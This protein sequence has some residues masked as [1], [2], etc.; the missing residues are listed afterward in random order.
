MDQKNWT[1]LLLVLCKAVCNIKLAPC[2]HSIEIPHAADG[3]RSCRQP[4]KGGPPA[5]GLSRSLTAPH[6][7]IWPINEM[8]DRTLVGKPKGTR[9]LGTCGHRWENTQLDLR[10]T[11]FRGID[12]THLAQYRDGWQAFVKTTNLRVPEN[13][14]NMT[15]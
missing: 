13:V 11:G 2:H 3:A 6:G 1:F 9:P 10:E 5:L 8:L 12:W 4:T 14:G 15:S 7:N